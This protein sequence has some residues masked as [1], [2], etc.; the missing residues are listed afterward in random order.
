MN[1]SRE[2]VKTSDSIPTLLEKMSEG[3]PGAA[4]VLSRFMIVP[5]GLMNILDMDDMN[6]RGSQIWVA[7]KD[8]CGED[9]DILTHSLTSRDGDLVKCVNIET[10]RRGGGAK[11]VLHGA[12]LKTRDELVLSEAEVAILAKQKKPM[13]PEALRRLNERVA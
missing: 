12:S 13:H 9:I 5:T 8:Y 1:K 6:I 2:Y 11:A 4:S 3:N 10:A 7:Y